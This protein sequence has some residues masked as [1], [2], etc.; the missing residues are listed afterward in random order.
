MPSFNIPK[1]KVK[2][3]P[4]K[5]AN[6]L[7]APTIPS[8]KSENPLLIVSPIFSK[9]KSL[10]IPPIKLPTIFTNPPINALNT[11]IIPSRSIPTM[12]SSL[13]PLNAPLIPPISPVI[14]VIAIPIGP[15]NLANL[16]PRLKANCAYFARLPNILE[17]IPPPLMNAEALLKI[18]LKFFTIPRKNFPIKPFLENNTRAI[19][20]NL[21]ALSA[22]KRLVTLPTMFVTTL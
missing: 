10:K 3:P 18:P 1:F 4:T 21:L 22:L 15:S 19:L 16:P 20:K 8:M 7:N 14:T 11:P 5:L 17:I 12:P 13:N 6:P 9:P 2:R